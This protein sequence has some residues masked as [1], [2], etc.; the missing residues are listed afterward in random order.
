MK[1]GGEGCQK[2]FWLPRIVAEHADQD[3]HLQENI[4]TFCVDENGWQ[5]ICHIGFAADDLSLESDFCDFQDEVH[6]WESRL[7]GLRQDRMRWAEKAQAAWQEKLKTWGIVNTV[8]TRYRGE[9]GL[10]HVDIDAADYGT[11]IVLGFDVERGDHRILDSGFD[12]WFDTPEQAEK[13]WGENLDHLP[14]IF[15]GCA[16]RLAVVD[17]KKNINVDDLYACW[18]E[19]PEGKKWPNPEST[20]RNS[21]HP[22]NIVGYGE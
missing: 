21:F 5:E 10:I 14:R 22:Q 4:K 8:A 1:S 9:T 19:S 17:L 20:W 16:S 18:S 3:P 15:S 6:D 12:V 13:W 7:T 2:A 11:R